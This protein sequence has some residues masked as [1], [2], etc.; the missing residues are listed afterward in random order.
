ME[1]ITVEADR[2]TIKGKQV[3][4]LRTA[5]QV[6]GVVYGRGI[7]TEPLTVNA[8]MME[9]VFRQA[10]G[11]RI[12]ALKL[13][14]GRA[15]NVLIHDVQRAAAKG[16]L[17]HIDFYVVKMDEELRAEIPLHF[18]G[19]S[20][21][22]YQ[23]EGTLSRHMETVE[24]EALPANLP[25]SLEVDISILNDFEKTITL[26]DLKLPTGVKLVAEPETLVARVEAPRTDEQL[27]ELEGDVGDAVPEAAAEEGSE[28]VSEPNGGDADR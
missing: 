18:T 27:A 5:G 10:G 9:K 26:G 15:R 28:A 7:K 25:E 17:T 6:P 23:D 21:A 11:N 13:G 20:T 3:R 4:N 19:E 2:R 1:K 24:V 22:V 16:E 14:E 8:K 12:I